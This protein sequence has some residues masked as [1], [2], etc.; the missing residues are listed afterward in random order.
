MPA[1]LISFITDSISPFLTSSIKP[2][3]IF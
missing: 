3:T 2:F 1:L